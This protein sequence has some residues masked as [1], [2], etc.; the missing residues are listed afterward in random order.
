MLNT[1]LVLRRIAAAQGA[2]C[3]A[4]GEPWRVLQ[5]YFDL[6]KARED[7]RPALLGFPLNEPGPVS[8]YNSRD[9]D[10]LIGGLWD[11]NLLAKHIAKH[12]RPGPCNIL[13]FGCGAGR[14]LRYFLLFLPEHRYHGCDVNPAAI[15]WLSKT[16]SP[17]TFAT[18]PPK[19]MTAYPSASFDVIY[20]WS[21]F[22]HY[23]E[24]L[25]LAWL[26]EL[27]RMLQP[28]GLLLATIHN[29]TIVTRYGMEESL[30]ARMR[31]AGGDYR[32]IVRA[33]RKRGFAFWRSYPKEARAHGIDH[34]TFGM[35]FISHDYVHARWQRGFDL[36]EIHTDAAPRWQDLV[37]LR[38]K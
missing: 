37:V 34:K 24:A 6:A 16:F 17:A 20:A 38:A 22:T 28:G 31:A 12:A 18:I 11:A 4:N 5:T 8:A 1:E 2:P 7:L 23:N 36:I 30:I 3:E 25:H 15:K 21:I 32:K 35:A 26:A 19:P 10:Y 9:A 29:D 33:Y 27:R 14:L 13:D